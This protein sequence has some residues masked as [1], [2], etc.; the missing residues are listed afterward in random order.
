MKT[1]QDFILA[2]EAEPQDDNMERVNCPDEGNPG[3]HAC[4]WC[5]KHNGPRFMCGCLKFIRSETKEHRQL[6]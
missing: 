6:A 5:E 4:G 3:H 1:E 2:T